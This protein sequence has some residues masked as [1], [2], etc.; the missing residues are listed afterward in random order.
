MRRSSL[1]LK[2][3]PST[4]LRTKS[5]DGDDANPN[6]GSKADSEDESGLPGTEIGELPA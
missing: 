4:R 5:L 6:A 3:A 2:R 1:V